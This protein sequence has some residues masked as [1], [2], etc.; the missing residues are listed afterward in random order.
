MWASIISA[1]ASLLGGLSSN[2]ASSKASDAITQGNQQ[3][4]DFM[5]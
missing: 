1:G 5:K 4:M 2:N 3:A